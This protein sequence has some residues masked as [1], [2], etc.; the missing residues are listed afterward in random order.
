MNSTVLEIENIGKVVF[1][2]SLKAKS[3]RITV[4][5]YENVVVSMPKC[6]PLKQ[7][8]D[9]VMQKQDWILKN[10]EKMRE[11]EG[12]QNTFDENGI[13]RTREHELRINQHSQQLFKFSV[14]NGFI[15]FYYPQNLDIK[16]EIVQSAVKNAVEKAL[17]KEAKEYLPQRTAKLAKE[18]CLSYK[19]VFVKNQKTRWG[20][21]SRVNNINLNIHLMRLPDE[22]ID[23]VILHELV[24]TL[25]K[26]HGKKF[27][28]KL[29]ELT[30][31]AKHFDK[32]LKAYKIR[33]N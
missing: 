16:S 29:N 9:F 10:L 13:F 20:S 25:E 19:K 11:Y 23:Y 12:M 22:L 33:L 6:L 31:S 17:R 5:P 26:N 32:E 8:H 2:Q 4:K 21:C 18:H 15:D 7:A 14:K 24:H 27:W 3:L 28:A 1:K 30:G